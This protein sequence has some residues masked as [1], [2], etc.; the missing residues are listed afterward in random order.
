MPGF[1]F[2]GL[3]EVVVVHDAR[4]DALANRVDVVLG[5]LCSDVQGDLEGVFDAASL[6]QEQVKI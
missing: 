3:A 5:L 1:L 6:S 4:E 2:L